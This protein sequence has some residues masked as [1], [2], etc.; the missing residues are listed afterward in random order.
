M[1]GA[2]T[3]YVNFEPLACKGILVQSLGMSPSDKDSVDNIL[4]VTNGH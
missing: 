4:N 2:S 3:L 1:K